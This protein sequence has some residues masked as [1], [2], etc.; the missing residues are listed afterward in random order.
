MIF[1]PVAGFNQD[2]ESEGYYSNDCVA[3]SNGNDD[4]V[5]Y[6]ALKACVDSHETI[7]EDI[8][9]P[10]YYSPVCAVPS[11]GPHFTVSNDCFACASE[12]IEYYY[13]GMCQDAG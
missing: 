4:I 9:C 5:E 3:C 11:N 1:A 13:E 10:E 2:N 6:I 7:G 8:I 12:E